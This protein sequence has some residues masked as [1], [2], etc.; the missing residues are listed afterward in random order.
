MSDTE[1]AGGEQLSALSIPAGGCW[2]CPCGQAAPRSDRHA[3]PVMT[4]V[5]LREP[6]CPFCG[7][8][9]RAEYQLEP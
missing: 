9:Y 2:S 6:R 3:R 8:K 5:S 7:G 4:L 1:R